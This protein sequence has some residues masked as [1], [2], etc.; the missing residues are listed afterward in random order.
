MAQKGA[1][2]GRK[3]LQNLQDTIPLCE[4][5]NANHSLNVDRFDRALINR[6]QGY[7]ARRSLASRTFTKSASS[8]FIYGR[9]ESSCQDYTFAKSTSKFHVWDA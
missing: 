5:A 3:R 8:Y 6:K 2:H 9:V 1:A 7:P 4:V